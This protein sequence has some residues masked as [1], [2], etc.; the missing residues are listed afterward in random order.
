[1][2]KTAELG[3]VLK[4]LLRDLHIEKKVYQN[5]ALLV[6]N[7]VVG[8]KISKISHAE[9]VENGILFVHVENPSW[10]TELSYLKRD[11][12]NRLNNRIGMN[13]ITDIILK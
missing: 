6:W 11:I 8:E 12:I 2:K 3:S 5:Q 10:R 9:S 7:E 1:M 13:I 4:K